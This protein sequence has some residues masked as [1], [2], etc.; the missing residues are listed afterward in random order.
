M[1][2]MWSLPDG[3]VLHNVHEPADCEGEPCA[4]H[5]PSDHPLKNAPISWQ[6]GMV[7]RICEHGVA[8]PDVDHLWWRLRTAQVTP[9]LHWCCASEC[10]GSPP[11]HWTEHTL[12]SM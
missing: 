2:E 6:N 5:H 8:H 1:R 9:V 7:M 10:C 11:E 4:F 12:L 3:T